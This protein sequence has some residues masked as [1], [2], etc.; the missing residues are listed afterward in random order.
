MC[1]EAACS[2]S[3]SF[4]QGVLQGCYGSVAG[5]GQSYRGPKCLRGALKPTLLLAKQ[6]S[7]AQ[8]VFALLNTGSRMGTCRASLESEGHLW[9][10]QTSGVIIHGNEQHTYSYSGLTP[11]IDLIFDASGQWVGSRFPVPF[12]ALH[13]H[14]FTPITAAATF[15]TFH[16]QFFNSSG[17]FLL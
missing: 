15:G 8:N 13:P 11:K 16:P 9:Y 2:L 12:I 1:H 17:S 5:V 14:P 10:I 3:E 7:Y 6:A 4:L